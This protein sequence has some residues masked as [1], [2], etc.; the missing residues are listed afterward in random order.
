M[1]VPQEANAFDKVV[2]LL[3]LATISIISVWTAY[4][5]RQW[6]AFNTGKFF[7]CFSL[8]WAMGWFADSIGLKGTWVHYVTFVLS[9]PLFILIE[10]KPVR[11]RGV[12]QQAIDDY[13]RY[14]GSYD[15]AREHVDHFIASILHG[16]HTPDNLRVIPKTE[17]LKKGA[18]PP[19]LEDWMQF[20]AYRWRIWRARRRAKR[21]NKGV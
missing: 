2:T 20:T 8:W 16:G 11:S 12:R 4:L 17:N 14:K 5:K 1:I 7:A 19:A 13:K 10:W 21:I 15:P 9:M 3:F 6:I 18:N